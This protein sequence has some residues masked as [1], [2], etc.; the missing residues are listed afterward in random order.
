MTGATRE[1]PAGGSRAPRPREPDPR[2]IVVGV[3]GSESSEEA[4]AWAVH[5]AELTG[6]VVQAIIAWDP[7]GSYYVFAGKSYDYEGIARQVLANTII[8]VGNPAGVQADVVQGN[9]AQVLIEA[10]AGADLLV[11][12]SRGHGGFVGALLGSVSQHCIHHAACPVVVIR[13]K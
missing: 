4:L 7:L 11:I 6:A 5:Q 2:R 1:T 8:K 13:G 10:S 9:P 3:D 12:G